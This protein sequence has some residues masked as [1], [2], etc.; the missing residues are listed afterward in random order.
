MQSETPLAPS[1]GIL[2]GR[3]EM[4]A[5]LQIVE[6]HCPAELNAYVDCVD[7]NPSSW[8]ATCNQLKQALSV[9]AAKQ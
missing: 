9:C 2:V 8:H 1:H 3:E 4:E 5:A 7:A 6:R